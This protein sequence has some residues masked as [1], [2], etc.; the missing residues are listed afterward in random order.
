MRNVI[1]TEQTQSHS[2]YQ[3]L[4]IFHCNAGVP[5]EADPTLIYI[6]IK[7]VVKVGGSGTKIHRKGK[8]FFGRLQLPDRT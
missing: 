8:K 4:L 6:I 2:D 5:L 1:I 7:S 3:A